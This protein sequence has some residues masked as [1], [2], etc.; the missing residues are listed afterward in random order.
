MTDLPIRIAGVALLAA[1]VLAY[2]GDAPGAWQRLVLP[3]G[4]AFAAWLMV[5]NLAAVALGTALLAGIHSAPGSTDPIAATGYP[6][7]A[8]GATLVLIAVFIG[9]F[10]ARIAATHDARWRQRRAERTPPNPHRTG[11]DR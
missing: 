5:R 2:D 9:R 1:C 8:A 6:L 3:L 11:D 4:M 7:V 10:R